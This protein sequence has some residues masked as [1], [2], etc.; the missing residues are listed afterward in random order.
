MA[1]NI[2]GDDIHLWRVDLTH[3][4]PSPPELVRAL[5]DDERDRAKRF[6]FAA[7]RHRFTIRRAALRYI[8]ANVLET[9]PVALEFSTVPTETPTG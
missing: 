1:G 2:I 5:S 8:L 4:T 7:D 9:D 6:K 3:F